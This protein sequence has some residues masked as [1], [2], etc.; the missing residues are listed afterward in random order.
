MSNRRWNDMQ[1]NNGLGVWNFATKIHWLATNRWSEPIQIPVSPIE[2]AQEQN[3]K[4]NVFRASNAFYTMAWPG[5]AGGDLI[6][7]CLTTSQFPEARDPATTDAVTPCPSPLRLM[8]DNDSIFRASVN[9]L[10]ISPLTRRDFE[11][12][13]PGKKF[14]LVVPNIYLYAYRGE[15]TLIDQTTAAGAAY[16][17]LEVGLE[18]GFTY[19]MVNLNANDDLALWQAQ[20][21]NSGLKEWRESPGP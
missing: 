12:L 6:V 18:I 14:D 3:S 10:T 20:T 13:P 16:V 17:D 8:S 4:A 9:P 1:I 5:S 21:Q 15:G 11:Q 2:F 19:K 7:L